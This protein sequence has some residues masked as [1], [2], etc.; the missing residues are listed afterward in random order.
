MIPSTI[1]YDCSDTVVVD[2]REQELSNLIR[3]LLFA[4]DP[5]LDLEQISRNIAAK[6]NSS[7]EYKL[8]MQL[9]EALRPNC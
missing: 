6:Q 9:Y 4:G 3:R 7:A 2:A 1:D 8:G 5:G